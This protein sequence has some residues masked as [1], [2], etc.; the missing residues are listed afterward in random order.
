[1]EIRYANI[2]DTS[3]IKQLWSTA[4]ESNEPYFSWYFSRVYDPAHTLCAVVNNFIAANIQLAPYHI[5]LQGKVFPCAYFVGV[6]TDPAYR[7]CG[8]AGS[9]IKYALNQL[10]AEGY[11]A[12]LLYTDIPDFYR[13]FG[14][15]HQYKLR[16]I[17]LQINQQ[18]SPYPWQTRKID[19]TTI[20]DCSKIYTT[21]TSNFDGYI[22]RKTQNWQIYL[23][24]L[25]GDGGNICILKD[26]AYLLYLPDKQSLRLRE[27]GYCDKDSLLQA[28]AKA[29][30]LGCAANA[31]NILWDAPIT[32]PLDIQPHE[33]ETP[34]AMFCPLN[35]HSNL[36]YKPENWINEYT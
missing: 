12:A 2:N 22:I 15:E 34:F 21:M 10:K 14:F 26:K 29:N 11:A 5:S 24:E 16:R 25:L 6:I 9:L 30:Q 23:E 33:Q 8:L 20:T 17:C 27:V 4:F 13:Q 35:Q 1:M 19:N 3:R 7:N 28:L 36:I 31:T 32:A 18:S